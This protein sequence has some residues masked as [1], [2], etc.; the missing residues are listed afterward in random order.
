MQG[1]Q[2]RSLVRELDPTCHN[3]DPAQ[4][5]EKK[6]LIDEAVKII[7]SK[8][9]GGKGKFDTRYGNV[10]MEAETGG[11]W[12]QVKECWKPPETGRGKNRYPLVFQ[13]KCGPADTMM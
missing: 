1:T 7:F 10:P 4:S 3:Q 12:P 2:V 6:N 9:E 5:N 13:R 11:K 8:E